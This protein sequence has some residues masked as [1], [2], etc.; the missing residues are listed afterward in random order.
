M[1]GKARLWG[2]ST[3]C[4][5]VYRNGKWYASITVNVDDELIKASRPLGTKSC[6][7]DLGCKAA[8]SLVNYDGNQL[9]QKQVDAPKFLRSAE[10]KIKHLS[11]GKRRKRGPNGPKRIKASR[12]FKKAQKRVSNVLRRVANQ[13]QNWVHDIANR[14]IK[15]GHSRA[16]SSAPLR[17]RSNGEA[18][19]WENDP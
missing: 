13:R 1:R 5:I 2:T 14:V 3:T 19:S 4:T 6:G 17:Y 7:I 10:Q 15:S 12:R 9:G 11:K 8:M 18:R 16:L